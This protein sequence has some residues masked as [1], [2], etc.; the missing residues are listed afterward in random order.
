MGD[1]LCLRGAVWH[2][3]EGNFKW[4]D[5]SELKSYVLTV[6][7]M[8]QLSRYKGNIQMFTDIFYQ[9]LVDGLA[10]HGI[11]TN[12]NQLLL[13]VGDAL[14]EQYAAASTKPADNEEL[15]KAYLDAMEQCGIDTKKLSVETFRAVL[16][17]AMPTPEES[18][19]VIRQGLRDIGEGNPHTSAAQ[20][21][22]D[23]WH[24]GMA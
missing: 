21:V 3:R 1:V 17:A 23:A 22:N 20:I 14:K 8:V 5:K 4:L 24:P 15:A 16:E 13:N 9:R 10:A 11:V 2:K 6:K 7:K 19:E 18:D 12:P